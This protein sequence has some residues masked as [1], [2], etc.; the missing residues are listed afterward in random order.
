VSRLPHQSDVRAAVARLP[1]RSRAVQLIPSSRSVALGLALAALALLAYL[2]ARETSVFVVR[3]IDVE[4][5]RPPVARRVEAALSPLKGKSLLKVHG[6]EVTRLAT[7]LPYIAGATYDRAFPNT[8]RVRAESEQPVAVVRRGIEAW[9][10]SRRGRVTERIAQRTHRGLPRIWLEQS[11]DVSLGATLATG[12]GAEEVGMLNALRAAG[13][14]R[15]VASV[16]SVDGEWAYVLHGGLQLKV[17]TRF[18]LALKLAIARRILE[19]AALTGYL[20][21]TVPERPVADDNPQVSG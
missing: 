14:A 16:H 6:D 11:V 3:T 13:L 4:G 2:G 8:L 5:V 20:D 15:R 12:G 17:G 21:V 18:Q 19:R 1:P 10:V 9:L 7:S